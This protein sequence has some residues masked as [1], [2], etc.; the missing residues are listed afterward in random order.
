MSSLAEIP[1]GW[2]DKPSAIPWQPFR[3]GFKRQLNPTVLCLWWVDV[4]GTI[5]VFTG[6]VAYWAAA[7][8]AMV[9]RK[10]GSMLRV[11]DGAFFAVITPPVKPPVLDDAVN[12]DST[13]S[14]PPR[15]P[16]ASPPPPQTSSAS[17]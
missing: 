17:G 10:S 4:R 9:A 8:C 15:L 1:A 16:D 13:E 7:D 5:E 11:T 12:V 2:Q 6:R 14:A 3:E